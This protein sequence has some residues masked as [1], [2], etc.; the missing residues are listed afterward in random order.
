[1]TDDDPDVEK[2]IAARPT[3]LKATDDLEKQGYAPLE[4][5]DALM[6]LAI[7]IGM[8][9]QGAQHMARILYVR[10]LALTKHAQEHE[11]PKN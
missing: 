11:Q 7:E 1:M 8:S 6:S 5:S 3:L 9:L 4:I 10:S 2:T